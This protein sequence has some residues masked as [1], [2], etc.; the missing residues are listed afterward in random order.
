VAYRSSLRPRRPYALA[1][2]RSQWSLICLCWLS[3]CSVADAANWP[4]VSNIWFADE[5]RGC[6]I[7]SAHGDPDD[8]KNHVVLSATADGGVTWQV[9]DIGT[10]GRHYS[11][12]F[13]SPQLGWAT[14]DTGFGSRLLATQ[15]GGMSWEVRKAYPDGHLKS[16]HFMDAKS[17][18][19]RFLSDVSS[20]GNIVRTSDG[21]A[22]WERV[23][24]FESGPGASSFLDATHAWTVIGRP[25]GL[26]ATRD[27]GATWRWIEAPEIVAVHFVS[28][29]V[30][31]ALVSGDGTRRVFRSEDGGRTWMAVPVPALANVD[32]AYFHSADGAWIARP[33]SG[34][35]EETRLIATDDAGQTWH[36]LATVPMP[37]RAIHRAGPSHGWLGGT[38]VLATRDGGG[39]WK[40][41]GPESAGPTRRTMAAGRT[42]RRWADMKRAPTMEE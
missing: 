16:V 24:G 29:D 8:G 5:A 21:G 13:V 38:T 1:S 9:I 31:W 20:G 42:L 3:V 6:V 34:A 12:N 10:G 28:P 22:S 32:I 30:G 37:V 17:G 19:G 27:G 40:D 14:Y 41:I 26:M 23:I 36:D 11:L 18:W 39:T 4:T 15:D 33:A 2:G 35:A 7:G 25:R